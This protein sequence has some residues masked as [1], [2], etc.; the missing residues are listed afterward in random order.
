M[1]GL[2]QFN[3]DIKIKFWYHNSPVTPRGDIKIYFSKHKIK[4]K[5][6]TPPTTGSNAWSASNYLSSIICSSNENQ[7]KKYREYAGLESSRELVLTVPYNQL[8]Y[9]ECEEWQLV[10]HT[11]TAPS[12]ISSYDWIVFDQS[13]RGFAFIDDIEM[14][15]VCS[16]VRKCDRGGGEV[17]PHHNGII[18]Y[19][20]PLKIT[21]L[22]NATD[23]TV[24]VI[25]MLGQPIWS[26]SLNCT[27]GI[28]DPIYWDGRTSS[29]SY[30]SNAAYLLK[31]SYT[32][33]CGT[34][35]KTSQIVKQ[36]G[37]S[38]IIN[39][40][41]A[42][43]SSGIKTP[44][45]CCA[46]QPDL[47]VDNIT[48]PGLSLFDYQVINKI[49]VAPSGIVT[50]AGNANVEMRAGYEIVINPGFSVIPGGYYLA[51]IVPCTRSSKIRPSNV[52][53]EEIIFDKKN[54]LGKPELSKGETVAEGFKISI[55]P[56]PTNGR[57]TVNLD[58]DKNA[59]LTVYNIQ[60]LQVYS[61]QNVLGKIEL[62]LSDEPE[63]IFLVK[64]VSGNEIK[65]ERIVKQ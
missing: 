20:V 48:L 37:Y 44:L 46:F 1:N 29:G 54:E 11:F 8:P 50:V 32:N 58:S 34:E 62:D 31:I 36:G 57:F 53:S 25:T 59:D 21:N 9:G 17:F 33:D 52:Y 38:P 24:E 51:E 18:S 47:V 45:P 28:E 35:T 27:N 43:N 42:C 40:N 30:A 12:N 64:I 23:V 22:N 39:N 19:D 3:P 4:Y 2:S 10:E 61:K 13:C 60:G 49:E 15:T 65:V 7:Y 6:N 55:Y 5:H 26:Y 14:T 56:N 63:G 41:I 16:K